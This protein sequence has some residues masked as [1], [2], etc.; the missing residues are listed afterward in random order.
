MVGGMTSILIVDDDDDDD[1]DGDTRA[2]MERLLSGSGCL[3]ST[4]GTCEEAM[5]LAVCARFDLL[6]ADAALPDGNGLGLLKRIQTL[7]PIPGIELSGCDDLERRSH[8]E[9]F[10][11][12]LVK[13][14]DFNKLASEIERILSP[15]SSQEPLQ[16]ADG[17]STIP[18]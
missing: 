3:I 13:P 1:D 12:F 16:P 6:I 14:T 10:A 15:N 7:Y 4:A 8:Q 5:H 9:E 2:V 11:S 18:T 17:S